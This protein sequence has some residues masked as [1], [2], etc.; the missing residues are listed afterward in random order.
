LEEGTNQTGKQAQDEIKKLED[1]ISDLEK[2][3][4]EKDNTTGKLQTEKDDLEAQVTALTKQN[5]VLKNEKDALDKLKSA[6]DQKNDDA[7]TALE[8]EVQNLT[9]INDVLTRDKDK[10]EV[11]IE[12]KE[13]QIEKQEEQ[14]DELHVTIDTAEEALLNATKNMDKEVSEELKEY[15]TVMS[16]GMKIVV[17]ADMR[18][19]L[20]KGEFKEFYELVKKNP[21][22]KETYSNAAL[23]LVL[24]SMGG[25]WKMAVE[26]NNKKDAGENYDEIIT[27]KVIYDLRQWDS[28]G[29][30][31]KVDMR[32]TSKD[33]QA[34]VAAFG[35]TDVAR[36][37]GVFRPSLSQ[38][39]YRR[40]STK[41]A[42]PD[43]GGP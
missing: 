9:N 8:N 36:G 35:L 11:E 7:R 14:I 15:D 31:G 19:K 17:T 21:S 34:F 25:T 43:N 20:R 24:E 5:E 29:N 6:D 4:S 18:E 2:D 26:N 27:E 23:F 16:E 13:E 3:I 38:S 30:V 1:K 10:K 42:N 37:S 39:T 33:F 22:K 12:E 28:I 32:H 41:P 40:P